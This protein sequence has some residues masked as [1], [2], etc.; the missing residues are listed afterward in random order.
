MKKGLYKLVYKPSVP[1]RGFEALYANTY[2]LNYLQH[3]E[4]DGGAQSGARP[5]FANAEALDDQQAAELR[6]LELAWPNLSDRTRRR[7]LSIVQSCY[8]KSKDKGID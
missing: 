2:Q 1:P 6:L 8:R 5:A 4:N 3:F 7:I